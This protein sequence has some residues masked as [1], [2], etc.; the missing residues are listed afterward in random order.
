MPA[1]VQHCDVL[2][3][4]ARAMCSLCATSL[5]GVVARGLDVQ[6]RLRTSNVSNCEPLYGEPAQPC[7][8]CGSWLVSYRPLAIR[9]TSPPGTPYGAPTPKSA[10]RQIAAPRTRTPDEF[11]RSSLACRQPVVR[12]REPHNSKGSFW[13]SRRRSPKVSAKDERGGSPAQLQPQTPSR[14]HGGQRFR[15]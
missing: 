15:G 9:C 10:P 8:S 1:T 13:S 7:P 11:R 5:Q 3:C 2:P 12:A 4:S 14:N 6:C